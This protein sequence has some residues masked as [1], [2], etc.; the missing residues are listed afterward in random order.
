MLDTGLA[1]RVALVTGAN[2]GIG[3]A[4]A[5]AL[6]AEG[7]ATFLT[8]LRL[9]PAVQAGEPHPPEYARSRGQDAGEVLGRIRAG[10][11]VAEAA[12][13][14][15]TDPAAPGWLFDRV[16]QTFGPVEI[17]V[18]N[19][20]GWLADTFLPADRDHFGRRT[21]LVGPATHD[22]LFGVDARASALLVAEFAR[23]HV[24]RGGTWGRILG[25]TS[26]G[27][28]GFPGEVSYGAAKAALESYTLSAAHELGRYGVTA[29]VL[30]PPITDT[31][32]ITEAVAAAA[33]ATGPLFH[34]ARPEE[35]AEVVVLLASQQARHLTAQTIVMR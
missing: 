13:A 14:D 19:A 5:A 33:A 17:L 26:G 25:L 15:L 12:E 34:V 30:H 22:A 2:H 35:V 1:G 18:N 3:A 24:E 8:Y 21:R 28:Q 27:R 32:W 20:S 11:G 16:A 4:S 7:V 9:D 23:R 10:G 29:N 6:A 31:G